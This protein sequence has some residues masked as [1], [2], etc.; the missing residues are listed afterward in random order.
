MRLLETARR[1]TQELVALY[2]TAIS[3]GRTLD[4]NQLLEQLYVQVKNLF[5]PDSFIVVT[6]ND[7][8]K[9]FR[10]AMAVEEDE[11]I[12]EWENKSFPVMDGGLTGWVIT[13]GYPL[14]IRDMEVDTLPAKPIHG[15]KPTRSWLGVPLLIQNKVIGA[16]SVQSFRPFAFNESNRLLLENLASHLA[17]TIENARLY[18]KTH[19]AYLR[20]KR[21]NELV[22]TV[23]STLDF[24]KIL[25]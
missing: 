22:R 19:Q 18:E 8:T 3:T 16:V 23:N 13:E 4:T 11:P 14:L 24:Q 9:Y 2:E 25:K 1:R 10:V 17:V 20:E 21:L 5:A 6:C 15:A 7:Q 12:T